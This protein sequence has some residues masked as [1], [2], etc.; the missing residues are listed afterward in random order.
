VFAKQEI[1]S[2]GGTTSGASMLRMM[3]IN[4]LVMAVRTQFAVRTQLVQKVGF[5]LVDTELLNRQNGYWL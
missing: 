5:Y 1:S 2:E 4:D 3:K